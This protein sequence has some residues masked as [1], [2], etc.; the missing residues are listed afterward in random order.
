MEDSA[1]GAGGKKHRIKI[2]RTKKVEL[3]LT[4]AEYALLLIHASEH[5][6]VSDFIRHC[7]LEKRNKK[8]EKTKDFVKTVQAMTFEINAIGKNIN[9]IARY[10]NLLLEKK[11]KFDSLALFNPI[12]TQYTS[13]LLKFEQT[14]K[15]VL[16]S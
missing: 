11:V 14:L 16:N 8:L 10:S 7:C 3:R 13:T 9:Q 12:I 4:E 5:K 1:T 15:K 6:T 2:N